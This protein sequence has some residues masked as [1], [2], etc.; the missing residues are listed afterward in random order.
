MIKTQIGDD[1]VNPG[2]KRAFEAEARQIDIGAQKRFLINVL[3]IFL[4]S[5]EMDRQ[6]QH[7]AIILPHQFFEGCSIS[8][9]C[10]ANQRRVIDPRR[11]TA[12]AT[13]F[14][15]AKYRAASG[16]ASPEFCWFP[17]HLSPL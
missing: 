9:L 2:I 7:G 4:R 15:E 13:G 11:G 14:T 8:L 6:A 12:A 10:F 5:G 1:A 3:T 17:A 16:K